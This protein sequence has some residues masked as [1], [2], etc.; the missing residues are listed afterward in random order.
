MDQ[1]FEWMSQQTNDA[2]LIY[3]IQKLFVE[4]GRSNQVIFRAYIS[5]RHFRFYILL[6]FAHIGDEQQH[7]YL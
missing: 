1:T 7:I 4:F 2:I 3:F 6:L 5:P